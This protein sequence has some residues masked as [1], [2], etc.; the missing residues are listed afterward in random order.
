[1]K[2]F[3]LEKKQEYNREE[4]EKLVNNVITPK[5]ETTIAIVCKYLK[6][7]DNMMTDAYISVSESL[8]H[9]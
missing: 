9:A 5:E 6:E 7:G 4:L 2:K 8:I 1:L 3:N